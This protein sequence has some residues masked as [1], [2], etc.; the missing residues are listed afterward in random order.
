MVELNQQKDRD[1]RKNPQRIG[2]AGNVY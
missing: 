2:T 1:E